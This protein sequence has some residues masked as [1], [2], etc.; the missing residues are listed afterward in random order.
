[1]IDE[2]KNRI[3]FPRARDADD[4]NERLNGFVPATRL[5]LCIADRRCT[6]VWEHEFSRKSK[7]V[8]LLT[9]TRTGP[10]TNIFKMQVKN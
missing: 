8:M 5:R 2:I 6:I 4:F 9:E 1:M 3:L 7:P 10:V